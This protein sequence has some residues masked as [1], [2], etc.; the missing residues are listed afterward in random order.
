VTPR[1]AVAALRGVLA[2][3]ERDPTDAGEVLARL[4]GRRDVKPANDDAADLGRQILAAAEA[5]GNDHDDLDD[6][7][8]DTR[9]AAR[10]RRA[11]ARPS[12]PVEGEAAQ[13][14]RAVVEREGSLNRAAAALATSPGMVRRWLKGL[15]V[16]G[17]TLDRIREVA[18][19]EGAES[20][21]DA[22]ALPC[23]DGDAA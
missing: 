5:G 12:A 9:P 8:E 14:V 6:D 16:K 11:T 15:P 18:A 4:V 19:A 10:G 20:G 21:D 23:E 17:A 1:L 13:L 22:P 3:L 2:E 7:E